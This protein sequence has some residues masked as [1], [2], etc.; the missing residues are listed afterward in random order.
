MA[1]TREVPFYDRD[2][3]HWITLAMEVDDEGR[4]PEMVEIAGPE[5][6]KR[7]M[8]CQYQR[9]HRPDDEH[10]WVYVEISR[11]WRGEP[12]PGSEEALRR[13]LASSEWRG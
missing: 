9:E 6:T 2:G 5:G 7:G 10:E 13:L 1:D 12:V 4:P 8:Q 11:T 3:E